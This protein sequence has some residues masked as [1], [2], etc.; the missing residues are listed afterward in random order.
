MTD[1]ARPAPWRPSWEPVPGSGQPAQ[2]GRAPAP[3]LHP[4]RFN[5][6]GLTMAPSTRVTTGR[7]PGMRKA[8]PFFFKIIIFI[9]RHKKYEQPEA[10]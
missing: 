9:L 10:T 4:G 6:H 2:R 7:P 1:P 8:L 3:A 5:T